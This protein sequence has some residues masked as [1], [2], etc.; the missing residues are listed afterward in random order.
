MLKPRKDYARR[1]IL[2]HNV[3]FTLLG[4]GLLWFGWFGFNGGSSLGANATGV[5][6]FIATHVAAATAATTWSA[7]EAWHRG[8]ASALGFASGAVAGLVGITP[9]CGF[10]NVSGAIAIGV[11]VAAICYGAIVLKT[12]LGYD[13]SLD[14]FGVHGV[15]GSWGAIATGIFCV[16]ALTPDKAGGLVDMGNLHRVGVQATGVVATFVYSFVVTFILARVIDAT[17]GLRV[18]EEDERM[19]LDLTCHGETGYDM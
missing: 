13:D 17:I 18:G 15:G 8:K 1:A 7:L 2:P 14:T 9:A 11:T 12:R 6:A 5:N 10:V 19:G 16:V 4:A 3:P